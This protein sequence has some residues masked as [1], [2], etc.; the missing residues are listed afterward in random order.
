MAWTGPFRVHPRSRATA[1][2]A[3]LTSPSCLVFAFAYSLGVSSYLSLHIHSLALQKQA[4]VQ[5][6]L[7][8][9][10]LRIPKHE[11]VRA[12]AFGHQRSQ[13]DPTPNLSRS[14]SAGPFF[15]LR[16]S[17]IR[18]LSPRVPRDI[19]QLSKVSL[20][21]LTVSVASLSR[22]LGISSSQKNRSNPRDCH[23]QRN[24]SEPASYSPS[25]PDTYQGILAEG[26]QLYQ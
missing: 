12:T 15:A 25:V 21:P 8:T 22:D 3:A 1:R 26:H 5:A 13:F 9:L 14:R 4:I 18:R 10:K 20:L 6:H 23:G 16:A 24:R 7:I 17:N 2:N 11:T 19:Y